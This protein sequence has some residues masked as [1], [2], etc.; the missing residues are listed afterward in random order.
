MI[1]LRMN[2]KDKCNYAVCLW[3][4]YTHCALPSVTS[5]LR[6]K[7]QGQMSPKYNYVW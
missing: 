6:D 2:Y 1:T 5:A 3:G 7:G 4:A